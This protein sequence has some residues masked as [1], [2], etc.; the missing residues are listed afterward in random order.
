MSV[1][2]TKQ[3]NELLNHAKKRKLK[4]RLSQTEI[5]NK[6]NNKSKGQLII[7]FVFKSYTTNMGVSGCNGVNSWTLL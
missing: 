7:F 3:D 2:N 6:K 4:K 5:L 1:L